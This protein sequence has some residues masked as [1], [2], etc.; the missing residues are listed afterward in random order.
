MF[1]KL[2]ERVKN[3]IISPHKTWEEIRDENFTQMEIVKNYLAYLL[4]AA[5]I[6]FFIGHAIFGRFYPRGAG[7]RISFFGGIVWMFLF[8]VCA[9]AAVYVSSIVISSLAVN[10]EATKN[11]LAAFKLVTYSFT[12]ALVGGLLNIIPSLSF[13]GVLFGAYGFYLFYLGT[14]ILLKCPKDKVLSFVFVAGI[15][16]LLIVSIA[17]GVAGLALGR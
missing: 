7:L 13:L 3:I 5:V 11:D 8:F 9:V 6:A 16:T 17:W 1:D 14:P 15:V 2:F 12:P 4:G 10:F